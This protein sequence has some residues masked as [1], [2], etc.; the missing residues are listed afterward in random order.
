MQDQLVYISHPLDLATMV[1]LMYKLPQSKDSSYS[2]FTQTTLRCRQLIFELAGHVLANPI[3]DTSTI[4]VICLANMQASTVFSNKVDKLQLSLCGKIPISTSLLEDAMSYTLRARLAPSWNKVGDWLLGG[5][6]FLHQADR[7]P[8]VQVKVHMADNRVELAITATTVMFPLLQPD[9]LGLEFD[10]MKQFIEGDSSSC[11][12]VEHFGLQSVMVLP[13]LTKGKLM[14]VTKQLPVGS[15]FSQWSAMKRYWK[16]MYGYRLDGEEGLEPLVYYNVSFWGGGSVLTYPEWT[17]RRSSPRPVPRSDP[18]P[19]LDLFTRELQESNKLLCGNTFKLEEKPLMPLVEAVRLSQ[20]VVG[21]RACARVGW[22]QQNVTYRAEQVQGKNHQKLWRKEVSDAEDSLSVT[23]GYGKLPDDSGYVSD[24]SQSASSLT[25]GQAGKL[26]QAASCQR[27]AEKKP[28][29]KPSFKQTKTAV[30]LD[31]TSISSSSTSGNSDVKMIKTVPSFSSQP[32][33]QPAKPSQL[34]SQPLTFPAFKSSVQKSQS[35]CQ[36]SKT[37]SLLT[38]NPPAKP[39]LQH[40]MN[41]LP[42]QST[43]LSRLVNSQNLTS[44]G[45]SAP[46]KQAP[47]PGLFSGLVMARPSANKPSFSSCVP[48]PRPAL[49][50]PKPKKV[51]MDGADHSFSEPSTP[52]PARKKPVLQSVDITQLVREKGVAGMAK[53]NTATLLDYCRKEGIKAAKAKCKKEELVRLVMSHNS[54]PHP[55]VAAMAVEK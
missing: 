33:F 55:M 15:K 44:G 50:S 28:F 2:P 37:L 18:R 43:F 49:S 7:I 14:S 45:D 46:A 12:D 1:C 30:D 48:A 54:I 4:L 20:A 32:T 31:E 16:N 11:L 35:P 24:L 17:V 38:A 29:I 3:T 34:E 13:R 19:V 9:D 52:A 53:V 42:M 10:T 47:V 6:Q 40:L 21:E 26:S 25:A 41:S 27:E 23:A 51:K 36:T 8:A 39:S 22:D 5:R